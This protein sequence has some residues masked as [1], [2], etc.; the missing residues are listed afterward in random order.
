MRGDAG[1][2]RSV[3]VINTDVTEKKKLEAQF[4]RAQRMESIGT[5]AGGIAHDI[6][7]ILSPI[8]MSIRLLQM[9]FADE[10]SQRL[11]GVLQKSAERGGAMVDRCWSSLGEY[12]ASA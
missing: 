3:L 5:L 6:N 10:D 11:L 8:L 12:M 9:K 4:L 2:P 7:N 1:E